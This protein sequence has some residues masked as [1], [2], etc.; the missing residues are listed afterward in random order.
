MKKN[1]NQRKAT[2]TDILL[3]NYA[4]RSEAKLC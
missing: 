4:G 1:S 2:D 3:K